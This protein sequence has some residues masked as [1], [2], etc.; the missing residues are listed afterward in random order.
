MGQK[1]KGCSVTAAGKASCVCLLN[2]LCGCRAA[3]GPKHRSSRGAEETAAAENEGSKGELTR[4]VELETASRE[5]QRSALTDIV[6]LF[7]TGV[8][9]GQAARTPGAPKLW[10]TFIVLQSRW[11]STGITTWNKVRV[12]ISGTKTCNTSRPTCAMLQAHPSRQRSHQ[13]APAGT[14]GVATHRAVIVQRRL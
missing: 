4:A 13:P 11:G 2:L 5:R 9:R 6:G 10:Y 7:R 3:S 12:V 1:N 14:P 8:C